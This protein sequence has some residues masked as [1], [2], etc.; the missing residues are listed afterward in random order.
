MGV[1]A[2]V[3]LIDGRRPVELL[4]QYGVGVQEEQGRRA[5]PARRGL[6]REPL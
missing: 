4:E 1:N 2:S 5:L 6:L 3:E